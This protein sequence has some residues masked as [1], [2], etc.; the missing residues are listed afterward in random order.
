MDNWVIVTLTIVLFGVIA[1]VIRNQ[2]NF[3]FTLNRLG[4]EIL[5]SPKKQK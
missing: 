1:M 5:I 3:R 4:I 2:Y